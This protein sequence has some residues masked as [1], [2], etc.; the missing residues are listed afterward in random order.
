M[1]LFVL[2]VS[3]VFATAVFMSMTGKGGGNLYVP[4]LVVSGISM[5]VAATTS[6]LLIIVAALVTLLIFHGERYIDWKLALI[7]D[8]PTDIMAFF[9]GY[10]SHLFSGQVLKIIFAIFVFIAGILMLYPMRNASRYTTKRGFGFWYREYNGREYLINLWLAIPIAVL[11]GFI[12]GMVGMAGATFKIPLMVLA[13]RIP[14]KIAIAT[15]SFMVATT[16]FM[17]FSGHLI[18]GD[19]ELA[20]VIPLAIVVAIGGFVGGRLAIKINPEKLRRIFAYT[21][22]FASVIMIVDVLL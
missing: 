12:S 8:P 10:Y 22:L 15:S 4:I 14:M 11:T 21:T 1:L 7:L 5:H 3:L 17:G 16:A 9:G 18:Q 6:Q 20:Q 13:C 19:M 2:T